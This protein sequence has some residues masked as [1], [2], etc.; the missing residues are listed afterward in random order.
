MDDLKDLRAEIDKLDT[1][2]VKI[3]NERFKLS[4]A[5]GEVK[6]KKGSPIL[7]SGREDQIKS[8]LIG[9]SLPEFE[10]PIIGVYEKIFEESKK[11]Q[12]KRRK[13]NG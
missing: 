3:L 12:N 4:L 6:K 7:V 13:I 5:V 11:L 8:R 10:E 1:D 2:L 9:L